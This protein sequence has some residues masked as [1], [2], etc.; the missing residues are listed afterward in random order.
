MRLYLV[1]HGDSVVDGADDV[2]PLSTKGKHDIQQLAKFIGEQKLHVSQ[3]MHSPKVRAKQT[4]EILAPAFSCTDFQEREE[5][6]PLSSVNVVASE[7]Y[8]WDVD[9]LLVG[10]MPFMGMLVAKLL[11]GHE[12]ANIVAF[13]PGC[14]VCLE[15]IT[16]HHWIMNWMLSPELI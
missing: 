12:G 9:T 6:N 15:G 10:H 7:I 14:M 8:T 2:R 4:A 3:I 11:T 5:L 13:Q 1:R 16:N